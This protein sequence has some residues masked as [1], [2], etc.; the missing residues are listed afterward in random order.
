MRQ[1][2]VVKVV[3]VLQYGQGFTVAGIEFHRQRDQ[4]HDGAERHR[5]HADQQHAGTELRHAGQRQQHRCRHQHYAGH[6]LAPDCRT[7]E[8]LAGFEQG[9]AAGILNGMADFMGG[10]RDCR[11]RIACVV[12]RRQTHCPGLRV[13]VIA[14]FGLL[15]LDIVQLEL[16][17]KVPRQFGAVALLAIPVGRFAVLAEHLLHPYA[18]QEHTGQQ[19]RY[20]NCPDHRLSMTPALQRCSEWPPDR[21]QCRQRRQIHRQSL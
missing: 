10:H 3:A 13:V 18:W 6:A 7:H 9:F 11:Q 21:Q 8:S 1:V 14:G 5:A 16:I 4:V 15:H 19:D 17:E 2:A 12:G 20:K